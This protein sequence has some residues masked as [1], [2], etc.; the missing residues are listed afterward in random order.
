MVK[1]L[2]QDDRVYIRIGSTI[3]PKRHPAIEILFFASFLDNRNLKKEKQNEK[4]GF[5]RKEPRKEKKKNAN[6]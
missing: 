2:R 1:L 3:H 6:I 4:K 5:L